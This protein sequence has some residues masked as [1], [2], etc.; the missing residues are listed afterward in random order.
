[1]CTIDYD[2]H[3]PAWSAG[4]EFGS[5]Q[6]V[7]HFRRVSKK[8]SCPVTPCN[9]MQHD[10]QNCDDVASP[11]DRQPGL[12]SCPV[13]P[14]VLKARNDHQKYLELLD[15]IN[16]VEQIPIPKIEEEDPPADQ[17]NEEEILA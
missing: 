1:M 4:E 15:M 13:P 16:S 5:E 17:A 8:G 7:L 10:S 12:R 3:A 9:Q 6:R 14:D 11:A 2:Q